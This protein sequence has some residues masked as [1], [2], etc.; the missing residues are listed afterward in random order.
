TLGGVYFLSRRALARRR[1]ECAL[2]GRTPS[3]TVIRP[4]KG[5]D[6]GAAENVRAVLSLDYPGALEVLF[7]LDS[8]D[9]PSYP[10]VCEAVRRIP[11]R[12]TRAAVLIAGHPPAGQT[13]KLNAMVVGVRAAH[14]DLI[15]FNDS[16]TRPE[17]GALSPLVAALVNDARAGV[18]FAPIYASSDV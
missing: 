7:V 12:A 13:G 17:P 10:L 16:D 14:G 3:V 11:P 1:R 9:D 6:V 4:M 8:E 2:S 15:A 18:A 5:L